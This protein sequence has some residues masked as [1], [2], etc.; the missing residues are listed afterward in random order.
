MKIKPIVFLK[1]LNWSKEDF[2]KILTFVIML[3]IGCFIVNNFLLVKVKII[4]KRWDTISIDGSV[5]ANVG[6]DITTHQFP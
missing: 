6:G 5:D 4:Q 3:L 1:S 2:K